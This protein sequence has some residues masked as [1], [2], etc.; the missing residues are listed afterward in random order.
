TRGAR[1][2]V[3]GPSGGPVP[4]PAGTVVASSVCDHVRQ[5]TTSGQLVASIA[6]RRLLGVRAGKRCRMARHRGRARR[7]LL[8][9]RSRRWDFSA[10]PRVRAW[11]LRWKTSPARARPRPQRP[12]IL[13]VPL[14]LRPLL[15]V[16]PVLPLL[17][18]LPWL[19]L[20]RVLRPVFT[21]LRSSILL[22]GRSVD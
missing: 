10:W 18:L 5:R 17:P 2:E 9:R 6:P 3:T 20:R 19:P 7:R 12:A 15:R 13:R 21:V 16:R 4:L 8:R 22:L 14:L 1:L 11:R